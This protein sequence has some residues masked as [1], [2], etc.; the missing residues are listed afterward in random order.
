MDYDLSGTAEIPEETPK[1]H[2]VWL[3]GKALEEAC[4]FILASL[5]DKGTRHLEN[6]GPNQQHFMFMMRY[7]CQQYRDKA[8]NKI[9]Q[10]VQLYITE[11][12]L[13]YFTDLLLKVK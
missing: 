6:M 12:Q 9:G 11:K 1:E 13:R 3:T 8:I 4:D 10:P 7:R 2:K 5:R